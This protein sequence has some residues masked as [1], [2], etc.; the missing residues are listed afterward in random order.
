M[1]Y[2]FKIILRN[3]QRG[4]IYSA[5]NIVGL[6]IG[7]TASILLLVWVYNQ[8]SYDRFHTKS[9]QIHQVWSRM[10]HGG[11]IDCWKATSLLTG[12]ALKEEYPEVVDATRVI[13]VDGFYGEGDRHLNMKTLYADPS[14]LTIFDFPLIKGDKYMA[15]NDMYQVVLTEK[16]AIRMFGIEDPIGKTLMYEMKHPVTV[17]GV[18]KDLPYNTRFDFEMLAHIDFFEKIIGYNASWGNQGPETY[19]EVVPDAQIA[20][21]NETI[22]NMI[23]KHTNNTILTEPFLYPLDK[24]Y[25][26]AY[27]ENG[28]PSGSGLIS[29]LR[30]FTIVAVAILLIACINF[31]NLS[32]ARASTR[33]RE[34]GV[35]KVMG[36]KRKGLIGLF[37][38]ESMILA[39]ISGIMAF[40]FAYI[41]LPYFSEWLGMFAGRSSSLDISNVYFWLFALSFILFTGLLAGSYPAFYL[42]AFRPVKVLK[43][44]GSTI[45]SRITLRKILV[46]LQFSFAVFLLTGALV[47]RRQVNHVNNRYAGFDKEFLIHIPL[48]DGIA[49]HYLAFQYDLISSGAVKGMSKTWNNLTGWA[50]TYSPKWRGKEEDDRRTFNL[51][52]ADGNFAEMLGFELVAGRLP[53]PAIWS[54]DSSAILITETAARMIGFEDPIGE[55]LT[56]WGYEGHITGVIKDFVLHHPLEKPEPVV[57]GCEKGGG[58]RTHVY[59]RLTAG[60]TPEKLAT[61]ENIFKR[62]S[63]GYPFDYKFAD[64]DFAPAMKQFQNI[65]SLI[66]L[67]TVIAIL[68]SC[69][70]L[71]ALTALTV[72]RR[73]KEVGIRKVLGASV[74][75]IVM[76]I[77]KEYVVLT[78]VA[79]VITAPI[80]YFVMV[81]VL[82]SFDYR[83]NVPV[84]LILTVGVIILLIALLTVGFQAIK[85]A[86]EN[87]VKAIK[88]E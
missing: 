67:F 19:V 12:P 36:G 32:T 5:I 46:V 22:C 87:P 3:L 30:M 71:F 76:L 62:Y 2:H 27:F 66:A 26:N 82:N 1:F 24:S 44:A 78:L 79:F 83:T 58:E 65:R 80:A 45:G 50:S 8:W 11:Q 81:Q 53:D 54:T 33:A 41:T 51:Y 28:V 63:A 7:M 16:A 43:S 6:A 18:M 48:P 70:G 68:I 15:I 35:R 61:L 13:T 74:S 10:E 84:W 23:K 31:V 47:V 21:F 77:S 4:G 38:S 69:M 56:Y 25:L 37:L 57:I 73:R 40:I 20:G 60:N 14:F 29:Q 64:D 88:S 86:A 17:T 55:T 34:V 49:E 75:N 39:F 59:I 72:E 52:F 42:S 85:A 9:D